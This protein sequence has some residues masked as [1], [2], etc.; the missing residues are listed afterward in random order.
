MAVEEADFFI[1]FIRILIN[2][3]KCYPP[4][5][6]EYSPNTSSSL[7]TQKV[8]FRFQLHQLWPGSPPLVLLMLFL[9]IG[10]SS[11]VDFVP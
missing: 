5:S 2:Q 6:S 8:L 7:T 4:P 3:I 1:F 10:A 9:S 11:I